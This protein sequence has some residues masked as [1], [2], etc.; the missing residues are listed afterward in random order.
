MLSCL[1]PLAVI[2][3]RS[4]NGQDATGQG[5]VVMQPLNTPNQE[6]MTGDE[7]LQAAMGEVQP[8]VTVGPSIPP[9]ASGI[10]GCPDQCAPLYSVQMGWENGCVGLTQ[11]VNATLEDCEER[12]CSDWRCEVW[13]FGDDGCWQGK[14]HKCNADRGDTSVTAGAMLQ[15]GGIKIIDPKFT[16]TWCEDMDRIVFAHG[17]AIEN[18][19]KCRKLCYSDAQCIIWQS[20]DAGVCHLG[21][22]MKDDGTRH[23]VDCDETK[24]SANLMIT[25][26]RIEHI[27]NPASISAAPKE[28]GLDNTLLVTL[29]IAGGVLALAAMGSAL[30]FHG[31]AQAKATRDI[32]LEASEEEESDEEETPRA[33][34]TAY[35]GNVVYTPTPPPMVYRQY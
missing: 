19:D 25:G 31:D 16:R 5:E 23:E 9:D 26:E 27:C 34:L 29:G 6:G 17:D 4:V 20:T 10:E 7:A 33:P 14:A 8:I 28:E 35:Q 13:Q 2:L 30:F 15:H 21:P 1:L 12:C 18:Q 11:L 24:P 32:S 22:K 3:A